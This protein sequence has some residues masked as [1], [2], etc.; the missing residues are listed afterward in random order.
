[1]LIISETAQISKFA[2]IEDS[3]K[4]SKIIIEEFVKIDSF[5]K[6]K[7]AGGNGDCIIGAESV[8]NPGVVIYTGNGITLGKNVMIG[9]NCTFSPTSHEFMSK[10]IPIMKQGF[11]RP[12]A[13]FS[14]QIGIVI[15]D[16]V[17][18]G[19][20]CVILEGTYINKGAII[21]AGSIVKGKFEEYGI[22]SGSPLKCYGYR[23]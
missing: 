15:E 8:I 22:Y 6:I 18:I 20:N 21:S 1:M 9:A 2:D 16:D 14:N 13:L 11:V 23:R 7:P 10:D 19:A 4:G 12:S 3:I 5:V 17:W